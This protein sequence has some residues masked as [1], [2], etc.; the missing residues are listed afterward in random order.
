MSY[1]QLES[2]LRHTMLE[3]PVTMMNSGKRSS[4][5]SIAALISVLMLTGCRQTHLPA[6]APA[7]NNTWLDLVAGWRLRVIAP[8]LKD[9]REPYALS[10]T[11][12]GPMALTVTA[13]P[14][15]LGFETQYFLLQGK[16]TAVRLRFAQATKTIDGKTEPEQ[17]PSQGYLPVSSH[18]RHIRLVFLTRS[19]EVPHDMAIV[20]SRNEQAL[21]SVTSEIMRHPESCGSDGSGCTWIP[22][23]VAVRAERM[24]S[25][26]RSW[27]PVQ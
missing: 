15:L 17:L 5:A 9:A 8:V 12:A 3:V 21:Q 22:I 18:T 7:L 1:S 4:I 10:V 19:T 25:V 26:T 16:Q 24:D 20:C 2:V 6:P 11:P 13:T 14:N 23:G 27:L